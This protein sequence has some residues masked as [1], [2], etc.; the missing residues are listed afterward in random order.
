MGPEQSGQ[1]RTMLRTVGAITLI[2]GTS[3]GEAGGG[4]DC[5]EAPAFGKDSTLVHRI[6]PEEKYRQDRPQKDR[7]IT[8]VT[9]RLVRKKTKTQGTVNVF[10]SLL[11]LPP[12]SVTVRDQVRLPDRGKVRVKVGRLDRTLPAALVHL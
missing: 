11:V 6:Y 5:M 1:T 3:C 4:N 8:F 9:R 7:R 12:L 10:V 2:F